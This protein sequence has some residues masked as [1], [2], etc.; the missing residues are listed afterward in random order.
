MGTALITGG[1]SGIGAAYARAIAERGDDLV[2]V[3]RDHARLESWAAE[4]RAAYGVGVEVLQADLAD[5]TQVQSVVARLE[6]SVNPITTLI[7]N[8]GFGLHADLL[9]TDT[10]HDERAIDVMIRA[11]YLL[12][13]AAARSMLRRGAGEIIN[14]ASAAAFI[15]TGNYSAVKAWVLVYSEGLATQLAGTKVHV[16]AFCPGWVRTEFHE[17]AEID[18]SKLPSIVW[19]DVDKAVRE[20]LDH[21]A[22]GKVICVPALQ[23]KI[24][25]GIARFAPRGMIRWLSGKLISSRARATDV[26]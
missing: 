10:E 8:A 19:I 12:G 18:A 17:R 22:K 21:V 9:T 3:A 4:L 5:R 11:V 7:N 2:L 13:G 15:T 25:V 24:G 6:S 23:W 26:L 14:T 20:A 16:T 1:T